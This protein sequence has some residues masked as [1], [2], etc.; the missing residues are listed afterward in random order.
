MP[1]YFGNYTRVVY[2][3]QS[4]SSNLQ[5]LARKH[6]E[7]LGLDYE[8]RLCGL[9]PLNHVMKLNIPEELAWQN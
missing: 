1:V 2:L 8:Y 6:A 9:D 4:E 7:Y 5:Q 3:A